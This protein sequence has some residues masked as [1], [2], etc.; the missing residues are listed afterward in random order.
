MSTSRPEQPAD[1]LDNRFSSGPSL[2]ANGDLARNGSPPLDDPALIAQFLA[3]AK[4]A[5]RLDL[6]E[7]LRGRGLVDECK[8]FFV[9]ASDKAAIALPQENVPA[10]IDKPP[11]VEPPTR[12]NGDSRPPRIT[13]IEFGPTVTLSA[14]GSLF[15]IDTTSGLPGGLSINPYAEVVSGEDSSDQS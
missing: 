14:T 11:V 5:N 12:A 10:A 7:A 3:L 8:P 9:A 6:V 1:G 15:L 4:Q 2:T 13:A